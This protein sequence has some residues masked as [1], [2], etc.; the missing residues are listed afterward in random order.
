MACEDLRSGSIIV[1]I[2]VPRW[3]PGSEAARRDLPASQSVYSQP[4]QQGKGRRLATRLDASAQLRQQHS[5]PPSIIK[6]PHLDDTPHPLV[7][8]A[9]CCSAVMKPVLEEQHRW[10]CSPYTP[11][12]GGEAHAYRSFIV[13]LNPTAWVCSV[14][15]LHCISALWANGL[16]PKMSSGVLRVCVLSQTSASSSQACFKPHMN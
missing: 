2:S 13:A 1:V 8:N 10:A 3:S 11:R 15:S 7:T 4:R 5:S 12:R 9:L 6:R 16:S 14:L